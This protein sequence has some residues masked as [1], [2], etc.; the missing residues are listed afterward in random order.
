M[1]S[2]IIRLLTFYGFRK[3]M[4]VH[5]MEIQTELDAQE[6]TEHVHV[7]VQTPIGTWPTEG[8]F[9]VPAEQNVEMQLQHALTSLGIENSANWVAVAE[10]KRL[11]PGLSYRANKVLH[12]VLIVYGPDRN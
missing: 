2:R 12:H 1:K 5:T 6:G 10:G 8:F 11:D 7:A 3:D 9:E 4:R